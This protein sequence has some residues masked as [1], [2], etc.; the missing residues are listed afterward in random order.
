MRAAIR[1]CIDSCPDASIFAE[2]RNQQLTTVGAVGG[3]RVRIV[4][5]YL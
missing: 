2:L 1:L 4:E 3:A 5:R